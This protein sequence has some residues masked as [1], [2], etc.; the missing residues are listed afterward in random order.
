MQNHW[1]ETLIIVILMPI[2]FFIT[3]L[4]QIIQWLSMLDKIPSIN[5]E[6][7]KKKIMHRKYLSDVFFS[8]KLMR[9]F[10]YKHVFKKKKVTINFKELYLCELFYLFFNPELLMKVQIFS[11][12]FVLW[13]LQIS[14]SFVL[15]T[16]IFLHNFHD[17]V[18]MCFTS[19]LS[20][21]F[22]LMTS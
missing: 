10:V 19:A 12:H 15:L 4:P 6:V 11:A 7:Y 18:N 8:Y 21:R 22:P 13:C 20:K 2:M 17:S 9:I 1:W 16:L 5:K 14:L 3:D